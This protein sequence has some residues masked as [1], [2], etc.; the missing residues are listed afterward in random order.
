MTPRVVANLAIAGVLSMAA[1]AAAQPANPC[2]A[3]NPGAVKPASPCGAKN[4]C[5]AKGPSASPGAPAVRPSG[6]QSNFSAGTWP[7]RDLPVNRTGDI[8]LAP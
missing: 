2:A 6:Q 1:V 7:M 8:I 5:A 4:P 3:M